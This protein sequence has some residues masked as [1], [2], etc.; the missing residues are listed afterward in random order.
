MIWKCNRSGCPW[1]LLAGLCDGV[2][3][4]AGSE[5]FNAVHAVPGEDGSE[6]AAGDMMACIGDVAPVI[7]A[8]DAC[9]WSRA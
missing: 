5:L 3:P 9:L 4:G 8:Q 1:M 2:E 6:T 7:K